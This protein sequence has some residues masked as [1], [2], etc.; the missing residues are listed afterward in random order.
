[1]FDCVSYKLKRKTIQF[2][3]YVFQVKVQILIKEHDNPST[4]KGTCKFLPTY[5]HWTLVSHQK[6]LMSYS[7]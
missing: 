4:W 1:M 3:C 5:I 7:F 6:Q 2:L